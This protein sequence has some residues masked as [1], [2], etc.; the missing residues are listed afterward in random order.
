MPHIIPDASNV[1]I[2]KLEPQFA[3]QDVTARRIEEPVGPPWSP[4]PPKPL[5]LPPVPDGIVVLTQRVEIAA[6]VEYR[7]PDRLR[8]AE[9][10]ADRAGVLERT[11]C[12]IREAPIL[13]Q[14]GLLVL[15][16][17][18]ERPNGKVVQLCAFSALQPVAINRPLGERAFA[19]EGGEEITLAC[20]SY[21]DR[22]NRGDGL[23]C[24]VD[25]HLWVRPLAP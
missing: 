24:A 22:R 17:D 23:G 10:P 21:R 15:N 8:V 5:V 12:V 16:V 14:K 3:S 25:I 9:V 13:E 4:L 20:R 11:L 1:R 18:L 2:C 7:R 6:D 19:L